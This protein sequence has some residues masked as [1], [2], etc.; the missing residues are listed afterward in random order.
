MIHIPVMV[1]EVIKCLEVKEGKIYVDATIGEGGHARAI[2]EKGGYL[3]GIDQD[4][5]IINEAINNLKEFKE[6][7]I[8]IIQ[9][10]FRNIKDILKT[11]S[12]NRVD[13]ILYDLGLSLYQIEDKERG[14][15]FQKPGPL[16]MRYSKKTTLRAYDLVNE[17]DEK[18]LAW[19][20]KEYGQEKYAPLIAKAIVKERPIL[21]TLHLASIIS[22]TVKE[23]RKIHP[24]TKTFQALRIAVNDELNA[25]KESLSE[26]PW[27][28]KEKGRAV[29]ITFHSLEDNIVKNNFRQLQ[30]INNFKILNKKPIIPSKKEI[31][32]NPRARSAKLR[33][34]IK[35]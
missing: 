35:K 19:I 4:E 2:L 26:L 7:I 29:I 23:R 14:F 34:I 28:L 25:L 22:K 18:E 16:D 10:N 12:I 6:R 15:S 13:G 3:I 9:E 32:S 17:L 31:L 20:I 5:K 11:L 21:D 30:E 8:K 24:A 27:L 1:N 33:C